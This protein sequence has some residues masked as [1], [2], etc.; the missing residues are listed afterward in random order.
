[1][2][3]VFKDA[4]FR[5]TYGSGLGASSVG[6]DPHNFVTRTMT[7]DMMLMATELYD[8]LVK[9]HLIFNPKVPIL[10]TLLI[11]VQLLFSMLVMI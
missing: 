9:I 3:V 5:Y 11:I 2:T 4:E 1:M 10:I 8:L 6:M 7:E